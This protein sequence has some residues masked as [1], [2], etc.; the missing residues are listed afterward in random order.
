MQSAHRPAA[1]RRGGSDHGQKETAQ[2]D[3]SR[4]RRLRNV[5]G[6]GRVTEA[7]VLIAD[8]DEADSLEMPRA[9]TPALSHRMGEGESSPV[10]QRNMGGWKFRE[11]HFAVP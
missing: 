7:E 1:F 3:C 11:S 2:A 9:L 4:R 8:F 10:C 5:A 6:G